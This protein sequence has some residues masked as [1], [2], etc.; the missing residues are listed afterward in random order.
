MQKVAKI[1]NIFHNLDLNKDQ[2]IFIKTTE[3]NKFYGLFQSFNNERSRIEITQVINAQTGQALQPKKYVYN[4]EVKEIKLCSEQG[5]LLNVPT[6]KEKD[7]FEEP[8]FLPLPAKFKEKLMKISENYKYITDSVGLESAVEN[9]FSNQTI[10]V[11]SEVVDKRLN[12]LILISND[13]LY[14]FD[15]F[16]LKDLSFFIPLIE[17]SVITKVGFNGAFFSFFEK[18]YECQ[19]R[20][21]V[22]LKVTVELC[23]FKI[24]CNNE[25][26]SNF[27][28]AFAI[29]NVEKQDSYEKYVREM[30]GIELVEFNFAESLLERPLSDGLLQEIAGKW[31]YLLPL[32]HT[33]INSTV[34]RSFR[35]ISQEYANSHIKEEC[36]VAIESFSSKE[37]LKLKEIKEKYQDFKLPLEK[38]EIRIESE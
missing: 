5:D 30:L 36:S 6:I 19:L 18:K 7:E 37:N 10:G 33:F 21:V 11:A 12:L 17:S 35:K 3:E 16:I 25:F 34:L 26:R 9:L 13:N 29:D 15:A 38:G 28:T 14:I 32:H 23:R 4:K 22:N 8:V 1:G 24:D 20:N 2:K 27:Q 31:V